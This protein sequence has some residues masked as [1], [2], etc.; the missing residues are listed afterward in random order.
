MTD[1]PWRQKWVIDRK[2]ANVRK[3]AFAKKVNDRK[4]A[5]AKI[6]H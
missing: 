5:D 6:G 3:A 4:T 1:K 2:A